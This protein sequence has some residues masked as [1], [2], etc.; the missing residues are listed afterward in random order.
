MGRHVAWIVDEKCVKYLLRKPEEMIWETQE[1]VDD[2]NIETEPLG[3]G[4]DSPI[5]EQCSVEG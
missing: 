2:D 5:W 1:E 4:I 3:F